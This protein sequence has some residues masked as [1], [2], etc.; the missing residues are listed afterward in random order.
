MKSKWTYEECKTE[1][2]KY[3]TRHVLRDNNNSVFVKINR[4]K[5]YE[6]YSHM[7]YLKS[8]IYWTYDKCK[9]ITSQFISLTDFRK[10]YEAGYKV[11][12]KNNWFELISHLETLNFWTYEDC[13]KEA[14]KYKTK[15]ELKINNISIYNKIS[16]KKWYDLYSHMKQLGNKFNRLIYAYE[17]PDKSCYIGLTY[18][19]NIRHNKHLTSERSQVFKYIKKTG[20]SPKLV[21]KTDFLNVEEASKMET[22]VENKYRENKWNILNIAKTGNIGG[23]KVK[24]TYEKCKIESEKYNT[25]KDFYKNCYGAYRAIN[26]NKWCELRENKK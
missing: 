8:Q 2:L 26:K 13:K 3:K 20:L 21:I 9:E 24:W 4:N 18:D 11:I 25:L 10:Q 17:F 22:I 5:W 15:K 12:R 16:T 6:L 1:A 14:L 7:D 23:N 19:I